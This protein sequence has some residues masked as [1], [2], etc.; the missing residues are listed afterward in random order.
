ML[1]NRALSVRSSLDLRRWISQITTT[2]LLEIITGLFV[3]ADFWQP[4]NSN[5]SKRT[6]RL[7]IPNTR[8]GRREDF[9]MAADDGMYM[10][11]SKQL[12][13]CDFQPSLFACFSL[14]KEAMSQQAVQ[15][16]RTGNQERL[17]FF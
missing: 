11:C 1:Q 9:R 10:V 15:R 14:E 3:T 7:V 4:L 17:Q 12:G 2:D 6:Y 16:C 5:M 8:S 13:T